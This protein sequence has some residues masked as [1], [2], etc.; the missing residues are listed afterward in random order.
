MEVST[1]KKI[2]KLLGVKQDG[3]WGKLSESALDLAL[4]AVNGFNG[5]SSLPDDYLNKLAMIESGNRPYVKA[6]TSSASGLFQFIK[7]TW[8][9]LG[10]Q[11]GPDMSKPF[12]GLTPSIEEQTQRAREFT[13]RNADLL[14]DNGIPV[15]NASLYAAHFLG[16]SGAFKILKASPST[17]IASVASSAQITAN[18]S[19]LGGG[20]TVGDFNAWLAK[21]TA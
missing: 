20:K 11:W 13:Q 1:I 6:S 10:G 3:D 17:P 8:L 14:A 21:K 5:S 7:G 9:N 4:A 19:I 15:T 18:P 2:Q 16:V 12:G